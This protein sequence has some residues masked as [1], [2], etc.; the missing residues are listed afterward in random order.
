MIIVDGNLPAG[1]PAM[2]ETD[3]RKLTEWQV[4]ATI[5]ILNTALKSGYASTYNHVITDAYTLLNSR[6]TEEQVRVQSLC[7][8]Q[9]F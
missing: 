5:D 7:F 3:N 9:G 4:R 1:A 8:N 6:A 2:T